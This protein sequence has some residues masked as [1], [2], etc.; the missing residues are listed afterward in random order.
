M[1]LGRVQE[2]EALSDRDYCVPTPHLPAPIALQSLFLP[3]LHVL[4]F[5]G[6]S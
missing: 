5:S 3:P 6:L 2:E 4:V 1:E